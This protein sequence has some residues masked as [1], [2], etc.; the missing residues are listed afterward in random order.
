MS[1]EIFQ[2]IPIDVIGKNEGICKT[3]V[4][5]PKGQVTSL[6][7]LKFYS[8]E[9]EYECF[10]RPLSFWQDGS[11]K[12]INLGFFHSSLS[13]KSYELQIVETA[14]SQPSLGNSEL[15]YQV[16]EKQLSISTSSFH[17]EVDLESLVLKSFSNDKQQDNF[18]LNSIAGN[19]FVN[20]QPGFGKL[21]RSNFR[22]LTDLNSGLVSAVELEL[23]GFFDYSTDKQQLRYKTIIA[24][25][26][27]LA[28]IKIETT[29][30]NPNAAKHPNGIWDLGDPSSEYI[31]DF[32]FKLNLN[33]TNKYYYKPETC[34]DWKPVGSIQITQHSSGGSNW[35]SP[36]HVDKDNKVALTTKG[37]L[38][39]S[40]N[41]MTVGERA[42]PTFYASNGVG[43]SCENFW[44]NFPKSISLSE[45]DLHLHLF[46]SCDTPQELQGGEKKT[47]VF[48]LSLYEDKEKLNWIHSPPLAK[49]TTQWL[50][51]SSALPLTTEIANND[52]IAELINTGLDSQKGFIAKRETIDEYGWRN[53]GDLYADHETQRYHGD[54]P[55]VSHYNNQYDP[56]YGFLRLFMLTADERWFELA[57]D[58]AKHVRDIDIYHTCDDKA[59]YNGGLFWHTDHYLQA[60]T[61]TH[62]SFSKYQGDDA[63]ENRTGGGG[64]GGQ[65]CYTTG[66]TYH[67][68]MTGEEDSKSAV[69]SLSDWITNVYEGTNTVLELL[70]AIKKRH[71]PG[72]KNPISGRYP[73][74]RGTGNY[75]IALLD[76]YQL[77]LDS[78]YLSCVENIIQNTVHPADDIAEH[79][80]S[81]IEGHW[82]YVVFFQALIRYLEVKEQ[83]GSL[84]DAFYYA[85][86]TLLHYAD[87]M[88]TNEYPYLEKPD[89]LEFPNDTWAA[90]DLRKVYA[91]AAAYYYS[92]NNHNL[93]KEKAT[94]FQNYVA[95]KLST[96]P[97]LSYT[98]ILV[99]LMQNHGALEHFSS[100]QNSIHFGE[101][102]N[103][104]PKAA[105]QHSHNL[106]IRSIQL[107][108]QRLCK[109]S[110]RKEIN[111]LNKRIG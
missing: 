94:F 90:Q 43:L 105:Y 59:D 93:Y 17:F 51:E 63:Y 26:Y 80:L 49:P 72:I 102:R 70:L 88:L 47:H 21:D 75:L 77:T 12:W 92:P 55:F 2:R 1:R 34:I 69:L 81:D 14:K 19:L 53:F 52:A 37:Y 25:F 32:S 73:L 106:A 4:P 5:L 16:N 6:S 103:N 96:S 23:E 45:N 58:L 27:S 110:I 91:L 39:S 3:G 76:S 65:H 57:D 101:I 36:V 24:F 67:Y 107:F 10:A 22:A 99:L 79:N 95:T 46:P 97:E 111:W 11:I 54:E 7:Q 40:D 104:W 74:D 62:R 20:N 85:R 84:D 42:S 68:L 31:D 64:P 44:Q 9:Q 82:F 15:Q 8:S 108:V 28:F 18:E 100:K 13:D 83:E 86:D 78:K 109:L 35:Q 66:L 87:W 33:D 98:R 89:I 48:W 30:H 71:S 61:A 60:Y 38:T 50:T 29:L 56:I 41:V